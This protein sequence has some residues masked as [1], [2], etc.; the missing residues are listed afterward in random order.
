MVVAQSIME[1]SSSDAK[2]SGRQK[3]VLHRHKSFFEQP[4]KTDKEIRKLLKIKPMHGLLEGTAIFIQRFARQAREDRFRVSAADCQRV[5]D[6][7]EA[8]REGLHNLLKCVA[9]A[10]R[11]PVPLSH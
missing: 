3:R 8:R 11:R 10:P 9:R 5:S 2:T 1:A 4:R 6:E 7:V